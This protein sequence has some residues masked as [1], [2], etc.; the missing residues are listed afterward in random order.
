MTKT[1]ITNLEEQMALSSL[2]QN[3]GYLEGKNC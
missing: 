2:D 1:K 3:I